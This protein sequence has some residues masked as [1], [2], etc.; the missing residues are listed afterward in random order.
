MTNNIERSDNIMY[1]YHG[2]WFYGLKD[3]TIIQA[4]NLTE[5]YCILNCPQEFEG[6]FLTEDDALLYRINHPNLHKNYIKAIKEME[7]FYYA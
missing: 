2:Y 5:E 1:Q 4:K 6:P 3:D 7:E